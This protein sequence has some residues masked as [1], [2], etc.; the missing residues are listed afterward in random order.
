MVNP[1]RVEPRSRFAGGYGK[2]KYGMTLE[3]MRRSLGPPWI[4]ICS[5]AFSISDG[6]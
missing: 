3:K 4:A 1:G 6:L 5:V 2:P